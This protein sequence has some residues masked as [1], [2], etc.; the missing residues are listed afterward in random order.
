MPELEKIDHVHVYAPNRLEAERWY[1]EVLD[2]SRVNALEKWFIEGGPLTIS[3]GG[4]H[5]ALFQNKDKKSTTIA[6][7]VDS[8]NYL[9]WKKKLTFHGVLFV[10]NDH[11][12]S[13]S[14]YFSDPYENPFEITSYCYDEIAK[15]QSEA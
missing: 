13:W 2:F 5:L 1:K 6:F 3:N 11:E 12:L 14:I 7:S 4:V 15:I 10:E 8:E 9:A